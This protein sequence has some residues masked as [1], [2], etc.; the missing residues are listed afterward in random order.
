MTVPNL[1]LSHVARPAALGATADGARPP[2]L[3]LLHGVG[4][5]EQSMAALAPS[6]DP[7]FIV[8]SVRSPIALGPRSFA[9][10]HVT[11]SSQGPVIDAAEAEA[12]WATLARFIDEA[13]AA[14]DADPERVFV[15]GFSQ[16]GIMS[17][18]ALLTTPERVAGAVSM[19]GR[20]LPE[21]LPNVTQPDK[22]AGKP[23][24]IVHGTRDDKL[25][26]HFARS[27]RDTLETLGLDLSY[28]ELPMGHQVTRESLD[29]AVSWL[30]ARLDVEVT[31]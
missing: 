31:T 19:S 1:S 13:V 6:F 23:A 4:S 21:L 3:I 30:A 29:E 10:F 17:L 27:A 26:I 22:I 11:F 7:R 25:G 15:A 5:N 16:G 12:G 18:A 2:L 28:R 9:W 24:L 20:L 8:L 14:Y